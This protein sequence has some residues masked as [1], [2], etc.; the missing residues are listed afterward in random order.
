MRKIITEAL[1][2]RKKSVH[3]KLDGDGVADEDNDGNML[4]EK[5][6]C[7]DSEGFYKPSKLSPISTSTGNRTQQILLIE[8]AKTSMMIPPSLA[9]TTV[10]TI[11]AESSEGE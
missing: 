6:Q 8:M 11:E 1:V 2:M 10:S 9:M 3:R 4:S 7:H 5:L